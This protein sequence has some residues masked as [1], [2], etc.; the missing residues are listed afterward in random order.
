MGPPPCKSNHHRKYLELEVEVILYCGALIK[1][2]PSMYMLCSHKSLHFLSN[3]VLSAR[4]SDV[5]S[6][7]LSL[8]EAKTN[9]FLQL[10]KHS[11]NVSRD[12]FSYLFGSLLSSMVAFES[13]THW[14]LQALLENLH[15]SRLICCQSLFSSM[16]CQKTKHIFFTFSSSSCIRS[17]ELHR[18]WRHYTSRNTAQYPRIKHC[19]DDSMN[20]KM[21]FSREAWSE[22]VLFVI[23]IA[24]RSRLKTLEEIVY[25]STKSQWNTF[26][27][28]HKLYL[29]DHVETKQNLQPFNVTI[30]PEIQYQQCSL[31]QDRYVFFTNA[32][33]LLHPIHQVGKYP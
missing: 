21:I 30:R 23:L 15:V 10:K 33:P 9:Y 20:N 13:C 11:G 5:E 24:W 27:W 32:R 6:T 19:H 28:D 25:F 31:T 3:K 4:L 26:H 17:T 29:E 8:H 16:K 14:P 2:T 22:D 7:L 12:R 18:V 1:H